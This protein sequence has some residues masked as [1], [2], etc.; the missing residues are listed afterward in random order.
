MLVER[1]YIMKT[2][3]CVMFV[4]RL[5]TSNIASHVVPTSL[6]VVV[7]CLSTLKLCVCVGPDVHETIGLIFKGVLYFEQ[8]IYCLRGDVCW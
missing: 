5:S 6:G 3:S 1:F 7:S 4:Y 8:E 2:L